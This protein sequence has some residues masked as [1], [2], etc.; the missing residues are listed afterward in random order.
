MAVDLSPSVPSPLNL[1][2]RVTNSPVMFVRPMKAKSINNFPSPP[3]KTPSPTRLTVD[4]S[5]QTDPTPSRF[6][7]VNIAT[8]TP[9][10]ATSEA[11]TQTPRY[12]TVVKFSSASYIEVPPE[13][14]RPDFLL[15]NNIQLQH[16]LSGPTLATFPPL[17]QTAATP[18][19]SVAQ[20]TSYST[21]PEPLNLTTAPENPNS[22]AQPSTQADP[23]LDCQVKL[24][25][26]TRSIIDVSSDITI[27]PEPKP[28]ELRPVSHKKRVKHENTPG[29]R[30][31]KMRGNTPGPKSSK[32]CN[33]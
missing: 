13:A 9:S 22:T 8:Q 12:V 17:P 30:T 27:C 25:T 29:P 3:S 26:L 11:Q 16:G 15:P 6:H 21:P 20:T 1:S 10:S 24:S 19:L 31:K 2:T 23:A 33:Q 4:A 5:T 28:T 32:K 18:D 14:V 7:S